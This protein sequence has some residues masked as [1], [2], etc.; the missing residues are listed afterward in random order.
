[1]PGPIHNAAVD[2]ISIQFRKWANRPEQAAVMFGEKRADVF[3]SDSYEH[4]MKRVVDFAIW[5]PER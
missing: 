4:S 2:V 1:M 3:V 5:G